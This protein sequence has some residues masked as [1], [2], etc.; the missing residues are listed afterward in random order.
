MFVI[1]SGFVIAALVCQFWM[2]RRNWR[3]A[4]LSLSYWKGRCSERDL[5][6]EVEKK[7]ERI[8]Y[9]AEQLTDI[10]AKLSRYEKWENSSPAAMTQI[11]TTNNYPMKVRNE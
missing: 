3:K 1:I 11:M 9:L 8:K 6:D 7:N 2:E 4:R 10:K 5:R